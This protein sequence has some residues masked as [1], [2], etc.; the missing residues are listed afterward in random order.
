MAATPQVTA[1]TRIG[2]MA[3]DFFIM[4]A[5]FYIPIWI[6]FM[7]AAVNASDEPSI[8]AQ[9]QTSGG[10]T[11]MRY[12]PILFV[13]IYLCKDSFNGRS[14]AKR[15]FKT[16]IVEHATGKVA[17]PLR[18]FVR[19]LFCFI[20]PIELIVVAVNPQRRIGDF[21]AGT[22]VVAYDRFLE[23]RVMVGQAVIVFLITAG[24]FVGGTYAATKA[25]ISWLSKQNFKIPS[26]NQQASDELNQLYTD[27]LG[28]WL[29][30]TAV[31]Y[32]Q[33]E[34]DTTLKYIVLTM[35]LKKNLIDDKDQYHNL[36]AKALELL[37][38]KHPEGTFV[39][40]ISYMYMGKGSFAVKNHQINE[41]WRERK[42]SEPEEP[43]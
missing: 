29:T 8:L 13:A 11:W 24:I 7:I 2:S 6:F 42:E 12:Y 19:N 4:L 31:V 20:W 27:S 26:L 41:N 28:T 32:D 35:H 17:S 37:Y 33:F 23:P 25:G 9:P 22:K 40:S 21:V 38:S 30:P 1:T 36:N 3:L 34:E 43:I 16:Q 5:I 39:G 14:I 10:W 18:C 15:V